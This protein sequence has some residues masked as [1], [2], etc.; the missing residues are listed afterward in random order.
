MFLMGAELQIPDILLWKFLC[1]F[2]N[3]LSL[4]NTWAF[5]CD[6]PGRLTV[7]LRI[8][9]AV[10]P[11]H[12]RCAACRTYN[13]T[14]QIAEVT[15]LCTRGAWKCETQGCICQIFTGPPPPWKFRLAIGHRWHSVTEKSK[16]ALAA[17]T[18]GQLCPSSVLITVP[19]ALLCHGRH[20]EKVGGGK[21][22]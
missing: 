12:N 9:A 17:Y 4:V 14:S 6:W 22:Q 16:I 3:R 2:S 19:C 18:V 1:G 8:A 15:V 13:D 5:E 11:Y 20:H 21:A 10:L 7:I